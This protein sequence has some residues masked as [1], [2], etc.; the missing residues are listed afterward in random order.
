MALSQVDNDPKQCIYLEDWIIWIKIQPQNVQKM[1][2]VFLGVFFK[3]IYLIS[4]AHNAQA[5]IFC[6]IVH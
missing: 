1:N 5:L 4:F 2:S 6:P 3:Y